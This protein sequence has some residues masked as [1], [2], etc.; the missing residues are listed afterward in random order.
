MHRKPRSK[1]RWA[2]NWCVIACLVVPALFLAGC[3]QDP[4]AAKD[5]PKRDSPRPATK[6]DPVHPVVRMDTTAGSI[7]IRLDAE[8]APGTVRNFLNYVNNGF[9]SDTLIHYIA[10]DKMIMGGGFTSKGAAKP[11][12]PEIRNEAHNGLTNTR[13]TIAMARNA[14]AGIDTAT[15]QFFINLT[16][17]ASFDHRGDT[18]DDYG[19][20]VFGEVTD[21]LD[22][23]DRISRLTTRDGGGDLVQTPDPPVVVK[24]IRVVR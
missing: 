10:A 15:S 22:V 12:G 11:A 9:Y 2:S 5:S 14:E 4:P 20:C 21:G 19:Y 16:D 17:S 23:A 8:H 18:A 3:G 24:A 13:G 1:A 7:T 6:T